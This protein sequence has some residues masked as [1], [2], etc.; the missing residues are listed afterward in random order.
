LFKDLD[1]M[2]LLRHS[3][4][5]RYVGVHIRQELLSIVTYPTVNMSLT[6]YLDMLENR[7]GNFSSPP[8]NG[9][10]SSLKKFLPCLASALK[11]LQDN[12]SGSVYF[13]PENMYVAAR[14]PP[15]DHCPRIYLSDRTLSRVMSLSE[16]RGTHSPNAA[17][18]SVHD[19]QETT[20]GSIF[21]LGRIYL[22]LVLVYS[23]YRR[24][25]LLTFLE[26]PE[27]FITRLERVR[28]L[29]EKLRGKM[30]F[31]TVIERGALPVEGTDAADIILWMIEKA[32]RERITPSSLVAL[33]EPTNACSCPNYADTP[34]FWEAFKTRP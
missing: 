18:K 8:V 6:V 11:Y 22:D 29:A 34:D 23:G 32:S 10:L 33:F 12:S 9:S 13:I 3:H 20:S 31:A 26:E 17:F 7:N 14:F 27:S 21:T 25:E 19:G 24:R 15:D 4:L 1:G 5:L 28:A 16:V 2:D 30:V